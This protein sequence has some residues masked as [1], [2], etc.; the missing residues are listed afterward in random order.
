MNT[1][2]QTNQL[3]QSEIARVMARAH[4]PL[5]MTL[6]D[7]ADLLGMSYAHMKNDI[8]HLPDFPPKLDR[9]HAKSPRWS[10]GA[11]LE[12]AKVTA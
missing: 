8:Q 11:V 3:V 6:S 12:W 2:I 9:F 4:P 1:E 10:R 7:I 5:I